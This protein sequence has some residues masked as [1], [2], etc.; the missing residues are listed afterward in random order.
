MA[1]VFWLHSVHS[2][3]ALLVLACPWVSLLCYGGMELP[4]SHRNKFPVP[5]LV[6][7]REKELCEYVIKHGIKKKTQTSLFC[8]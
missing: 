1:S 7:G 2:L 8:T 6:L 4:V 3:A 5:E